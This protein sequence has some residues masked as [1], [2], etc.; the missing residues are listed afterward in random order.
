MCFQGILPLTIMK[1]PFRDGALVAGTMGFSAQ[2]NVFAETNSCFQKK[3]FVFLALVVQ[4]DSHTTCQ[5]TVSMVYMV[6]RS[7]LRA[8]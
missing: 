5:R 7:L 6:E 1:Q 3:L 4:V 2:F 8:A